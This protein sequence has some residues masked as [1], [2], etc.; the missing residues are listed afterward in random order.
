VS[1]LA[2]TLPSPEFDL[3]LCQLCAGDLPPDQA[4]KLI[5]RLESDDRACEAYVRYL[6][7]HAELMWRYGGQHHTVEPVQLASTTPAPAKSRKSLY[8]RLTAL[9][10]SMLLIAYFVGMMVY[11]SLRHKAAPTDLVATAPAFVSASDGAEWRGQKSEIRNQKS[12]VISGEPLEIAAGLVELKLKQGVTLT[13][14]GP[15][16]WSIDGDN[17][18]TLRWGKV[19]VVVPP[20]AV[21]FLLK[22]PAAQIVDLGTEFTAEAN[23]KSETTVQVIRGKVEIADDKRGPASQRITAG[24]ARRIRLAANGEPLVDVI[25]FNAAQAS[26]PQIAEKPFERWRNASQKL[27]KDASLVAYYDFEDHPY[28]SLPKDEPSRQS[29]LINAQADK[30]HGE[31]T[32]PKRDSSWTTGRWREKRGLVLGPNFASAQ[33]PDDPSLH[34]NGEGTV[35]V[36]F[37]PDTQP[38]RRHA[39]IVA[40]GELGE[41]GYSLWLTSKGR[42]RFFANRVDGTACFCDS[43]M[44]VDL[45]R[46]HLAVGTIASGELRLYLDGTAAC[47]PCNY[48]G[49]IATSNTPLRLGGS[50][51]KKGWPIFVGVVDELAIFN[52]TLTPAEIAAM[53]EAGSP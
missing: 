52:R 44:A 17:R 7:L 47:E 10:A 19:H 39:R 26:I 41:C 25:P 20:R 23:S 35:A 8:I 1:A 13:M 6:N 3:L 31:I 46:W 45:N 29:L 4:A 53:Y 48:D 32:S 34:L 22:T 51:K 16:E 36:W 38:K 11:V 49:Q 27:L 42:M 33:V 28:A 2:N 15:A 40:K 24:Q 12:E 9:A 50:V 5:G 43:T 30:L 18:A 37:R 14:Q 21:G